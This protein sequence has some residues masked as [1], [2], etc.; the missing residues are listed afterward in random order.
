MKHVF[1]KAKDRLKEDELWHLE[2]YLNL[3][4]ELREAYEL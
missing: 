2:S 1:H 3:S 4:T